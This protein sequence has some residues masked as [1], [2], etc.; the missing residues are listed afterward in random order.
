M[1]HFMSNTISAFDYY[2]EAS[3]ATTNVISFIY[4]NVRLNLSEVKVN[5]LHLESKG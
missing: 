4:F 3:L 5:I 1:L 2:L